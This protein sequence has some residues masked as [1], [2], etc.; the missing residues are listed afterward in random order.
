MGKRGWAVVLSKKIRKDPTGKVTSEQR[1]EL[2]FRVV[3]KWVRDRILMPLNFVHWA[4]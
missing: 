3:W 2:G 4:T 1:V